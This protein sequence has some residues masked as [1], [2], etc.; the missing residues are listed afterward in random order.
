MNFLIEEKVLE[1][2][3]EE[4]PKDSKIVLLKM[5]DLQAPQIG[6][7]GTVRGVDDIGSILVSWHRRGSLNVVYGVDI[8]KRIT[9][10]GDAEPVP[11]HDSI[12]T[13]ALKLSEANIPYELVAIEDGWEITCNLKDRKLKFLRYTGCTSYE[14][15]LCPNEVYM[16][17]IPTDKSLAAF[18]GIVILQSAFATAKHFWE[19]SQSDE[20]NSS[21]QTEFICYENNYGNLCIDNDAI[22]ERCVIKDSFDT[23]YNYLCDRILKGVALGF[24]VDESQKDYTKIVVRKKLDDCG[25]YALLMVYDEQG[26]D[27][28]SY[29]II[30]EKKIKE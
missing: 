9:I 10:D 23:A 20:Q 27:Y 13:L 25:R 3:R 16:H 29:S 2:L 24:D 14:Y 11:F 4:Y 21:G 17:S 1:Q 30:I 28:D 15:T 26:N 5:D 12:L 8:A 7:I 18:D 22:Q 6:T 19:Q